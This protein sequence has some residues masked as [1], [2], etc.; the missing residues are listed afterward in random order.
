[1]RPLHLRLLAADRDRDEVETLVAA[2][3]AAGHQVVTA[4]DQAPPGTVSAFPDFYIT[5]GTGGNAPESL[6]GAEARHIAAVLRY[7]GGNRRR[8][9]L[10]LGIARSTL[11]AKIRRY[12][13]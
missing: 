11:L 3:R 6:E 1:M 8:A 9:A 4:A 5:E 7:A 12:G 10:L 2:L 13:L